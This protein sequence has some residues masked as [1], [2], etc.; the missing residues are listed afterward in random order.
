MTV[1]S[2]LIPSE[3]LLSIY[4]FSVNEAQKLDLLSRSL[5]SAVSIR[6]N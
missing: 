3:K 6:T 4:Y 2:R 1:V 5:F